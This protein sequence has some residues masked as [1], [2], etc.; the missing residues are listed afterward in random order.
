MNHKWLESNTKPTSRAT[1]VTEG[2]TKIDTKSFSRWICKD[3]RKHS[4]CMYHKVSLGLSQ[5][6][7]MIR[8]FADSD[9]FISLPAKCT[10][11]CLLA[12]LFSLWFVGFYPILNVPR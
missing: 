6:F 11:K 10:E 9:T 1:Q 4:S 8:L 2:Y 12:G 5:T 7:K 3:F